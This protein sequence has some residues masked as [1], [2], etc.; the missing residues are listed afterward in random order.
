MTLYKHLTAFA[1]LALLSTGTAMADEFTVG[2]YLYTVVGPK[3]VSVAAAPN[4]SDANAEPLIAGNITLPSSVVHDGVTYTVTAIT[5]KGFFNTLHVTGVTIPEGIKKV[6]EY[7]FYNC[8]MTY[9]S[10]PS[11][12]TE[13][14]EGAFFACDELTEVTLPQNFKILGRM[15]FDLCT[16]LASVTIPSTCT[17]ILGGAFSGCSSL[18]EVT[19]PT[20][21]LN[22]AGTVF[23]NCSSLRRV[24]LPQNITVLNGELF[25]GCSSLESI[26]IPATVE[27]INAMCFRGC[28]SLTHVDIPDAVAVLNINAFED[29]T[30]LES[31]SLPA[32]LGQIGQQAFKNCTALR[33]ITL[34]AGSGT[35]GTSAFEGCTALQNITFLAPSA[36]IPYVADGFRLPQVT[37]GTGVTEVYPETSR[38][39]RDDAGTTWISQT[40]S[41]GSYIDVIQALPGDASTPALSFNQP[42]AYYE[43]TSLVTGRVIN[44][45]ATALADAP[46]VTSLTL[47]GANCTTS[48]N[49][50]AGLTGLQEVTLATNDT[51]ITGQ[52][53]Q[54]LRCIHTYYMTPPPCPAMFTQ[55]TYETCRLDIPDPDSVPA[56]KAAEG[57][58]L[59]F[60]PISGISDISDT[61]DASDMPTYDLTGRPASRGLLIRADGTKIIR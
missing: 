31:I 54:N 44:E 42:V 4:P 49:D 40:V 2:D 39:V 52:W 13:T 33:D 15:T 20:K 57:W 45:P 30:S 14:E 21:M 55:T 9:L 22:L 27:N 6:T 10:L 23:Y 16:K 37:L 38:L 26:D 7:A 35:P 43:P 51:P 19:L 36:K 46:T 28:S 8:N 48:G 1:L 50:Y 61:S 56:Y 32:G 59:F 47:D 11:T 41:H 29:C 17:K 12:L 58:K 53:G 25:E 60:G 24:T 18:T 34:P 5:K 3:K